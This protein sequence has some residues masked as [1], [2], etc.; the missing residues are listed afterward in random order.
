MRDCEDCIHD[1]CCVILCG[2]RHFRSRWGRCERCGE[3]F[4]V[5]ELDENGLC[6]TCSEVDAREYAEACGE[7]E[8]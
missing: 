5:E 3:T 1:G 2:G 7:E 4:D 8:K 6:E